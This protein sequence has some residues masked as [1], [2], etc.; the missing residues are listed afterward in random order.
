MY[1]SFNTKS[2]Y[3]FQ[4]HS[5]T[6]FLIELYNVTHSPGARCDTQPTPR[7][8]S[9][10]YCTFTQFTW[11]WPFRSPH[12]CPHIYDPLPLG[13]LPSPPFFESSFASGYSR[14]RYA[15][16]LGNVPWGMVGCTGFRIMGAGPKI[17]H[18]SMT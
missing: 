3:R 5:I 16:D 8:S 6:L 15:C 10:E 9:S 7:H 4:L 18:V 17:R 2:S 13:G 12:H 14:L 1:M 11:C